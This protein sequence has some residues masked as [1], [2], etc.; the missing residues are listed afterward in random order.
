MPDS[1]S[2]GI[3]QSRWNG[4]VRLKKLNFL[5]LIFISSQWIHQQ[6]KSKKKN[7]THT[8]WDRNKQTK[9]ERERKKEGRKDGRKEIRKRIR[10][11]LANF[12]SLPSASQNGS[13]K[14]L[15]F[16]L[17]H[18]HGLHH[19]HNYVRAGPT[20]SGHYECAALI[21]ITQLSICSIFRV[22]P[23][24]NG[25]EFVTC[26]GKLDKK[27]KSRLEIKS[28]LMPSHGRVITVVSIRHDFQ[29]VCLNS[30]ERK[31]LLR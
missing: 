2:L 24:E 18:S 10:L 17:H 22:E 31:Q 27:K 26:N 30:A 15:A 9:R 13:N 5:S 23:S 1:L 8:R 3:D 16:N 19:L 12:A 25:A 20:L 11:N 28:K 29:F 4:R 6:E 14:N 21:L 7:H